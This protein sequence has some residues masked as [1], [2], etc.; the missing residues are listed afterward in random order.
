[1]GGWLDHDV[2]RPESQVMSWDDLRA[3]AAKGWAIGGHTMNHPQLSGLSAD[4]QRR[5]ISGCKQKLEAVLE[6][7]V[8]AFAY[9]F[10][11]ALD[12]TEASRE[13]VR[14][15]GYSFALSNRFGVNTRRADRW[16]LRRIW[17]DRGD[18]L[19]SFRAKVEGRLDRLA[20]LDS[21]V[22][23]RARRLMNQVLRAG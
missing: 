9:P 20:W 22:G 23:I 17:V 21:A 15:S 16:A 19:E 18:T 1:M 2:C 7:P 8:E 10:G 6:A 5:E 3:L 11:S 4:E 14:E 13:I 12:Y